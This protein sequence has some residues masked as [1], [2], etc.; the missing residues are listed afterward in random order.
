[1]CREKLR[2]LKGSFV[3]YKN[4]LLDAFGGYFLLLLFITQCLLKGIVFSIATEGILPLF[5]SMG[6]TAIN[7]QIYGALALTPWT[8][9]PLFGII[10]DLIAIDGYHKRHWMSLSVI[11]GIVGASL[12]VTQPAVPIALTFFL[13][14]IHTEISV[15]DLLSEGKYAEVMRERPETGSDIVTLAQG[16]QNLGV[17]IGISIIG[18]LSDSGLFRIYNIVALIL[19]V[20]PLTPIL[21]GWMPEEQRSGPWVML[22][23][24]ELSKNWKIIV[25]VAFVGITAPVMASITAFASKLIGLISSVVVLIIG[26][27]GGYLWF[28]H[29]LIGN[30]ALYQVITMLAKI[31][32]GG[33]LS[34]FFLADEVCLPGGPAF[35]Y[36]FYITITGIV[37][38]VTS[39]LTV[40]LYQA[41]FSTWKYRNVLI[42]TS[43]LA[44]L[45]G[46]FDFIIVKRWNLAMGIP[47]SWFFLIGDDVLHNLVTM[48]YWIPSSSIIGKV[49][50]KGMESST[51]AYLAGISNFARMVSTIAGAWLAEIFGVV[52]SGENCYWEPLPWLILGGHILLVLVV[53]IPAAWLIP[54]IGQRE[55]IMNGGIVILQEEN[56]TEEISLDDDDFENPMDEFTNPQGDE[57]D[58]D[59]NDLGRVAMD[60]H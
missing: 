17:V 33:P 21:R 6:V 39:L 11:V 24:Q 54:N 15:C 52:S 42:F 3:A 31:S 1:M 58:F 19:C 51:F 25:I 20:V 56:G 50:P 8:I 18:P 41:L 53:S 60:F 26:V 37:G 16:F 43:I 49:C 4:R 9:K 7:L 22:D 57:D 55:D 14:M 23:T 28:P 30:V 36:N 38:A 13:F 32:F 44:S 12:M 29:R 34:Y 10:S 48:L 40:F 5:K 46:I 27:V 59:E 2:G 47:D 45:G 35:S